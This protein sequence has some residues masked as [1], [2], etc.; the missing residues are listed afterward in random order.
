MQHLYL[1]SFPLCPVIRGRDHSPF[2]SVVVETRVSAFV[3]S[4]SRA[5]CASSLFSLLRLT[6]IFFFFLLLHGAALGSRCKRIL[7][8]CEIDGAAAERRHSCDRPGCSTIPSLD[9]GPSRSTTR[10]NHA[11]LFTST[12]CH[13]TARGR[14]HRAWTTTPLRLTPSRYACV[15]M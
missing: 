2:T 7:G 14:A 11:T 8:R 5:I 6:R 15:Y 1:K 10:R 3:S 12:I 13:K 9:S 4:S